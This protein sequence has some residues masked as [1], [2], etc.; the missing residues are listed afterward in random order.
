MGHC[1]ACSIQLLHMYI[2]ARRITLV[3]GTSAVPVTIHMY[4]AVPI[5]MMS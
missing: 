4:R 3:A 1:R 5:C 2:A